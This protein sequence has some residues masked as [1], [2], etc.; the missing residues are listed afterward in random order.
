MSSLYFMLFSS[1]FLPHL[2]PPF[3]YSPT[4]TSNVGSFK[5][6]FPLRYDIVS[7]CELGQFVNVEID[8]GEQSILVGVNIGNSDTWIL[9]TGYE[10]INTIDNSILHQSACGY[11]NITYDISPSFTN[12]AN[13][14]LDYIPPNQTP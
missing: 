3:E 12:I 13:R 8:F 14:T 4:S 6:R 1:A 11:A 2:C 10:C 7:L 5:A 9:G